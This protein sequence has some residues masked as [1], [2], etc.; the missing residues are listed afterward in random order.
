[1]PVIDV[2][3]HAFPDELA[4]RAVSRIE[5]LAGVRAVLDGTVS[6][7]LRSMDAAGIEH[8]VVLSIATKPSQFESILAWSRKVECPRIL[9]LLSVHPAD[10]DA[11]EHVRICAEEGFKGLKFHPYYQDFDLDDPLMDPIYAAMEERGLICV[12][13]TGYDHAFPFVRRAEPLRILRVLKRFP[14]LAFVATHLGAWK[15]WELAVQHLPGAPVWIDTAYSLEFLPPQDAR[16]LLQSFP[17]ERLLFGSDSP[18]AG[19]ERSL[20]LLK[21]LGLDSSRQEGMMGDNARVLFGL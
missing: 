4:P 5:G 8:S 13:H 14:R 10:P 7:L 1:M 3:A 17:P 2:H 6:S 18:W 16:T 20:A 19:Q 21:G 9:C 11:A 15:D 12:S